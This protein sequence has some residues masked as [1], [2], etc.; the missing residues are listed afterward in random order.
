MFRQQASS[1]VKNIFRMH[2]MAR[3]VSE[4]L[5]TLDIR[6]QAML[7]IV[8]LDFD[9]YIAPHVRHPRPGQL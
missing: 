3:S 1:H 4:P 7:S 6:G 5:R 2:H 8:E 9:G